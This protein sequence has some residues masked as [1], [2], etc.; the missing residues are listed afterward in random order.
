MNNSYRYVFCD[1]CGKKLFRITEDSEYKK[2]YIWCKT[3][4]KEI[5]LNDKKSQRAK[6]K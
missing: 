6:V 1:I 4:K 5:E 3:C 2:I